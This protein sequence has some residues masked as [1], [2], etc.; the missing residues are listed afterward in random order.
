[1]G[2]LVTFTTTANDA[3]A[4][5]TIDGA[6]WKCTMK[7]KTSDLKLLKGQ[8]RI[9]NHW[10][11]QKEKPS[12]EEFKTFN[13]FNKPNNGKTVIAFNDLRA[14]DKERNWH[15]GIKGTAFLKLERLGYWSGRFVDAKGRHW[16]F[17]CT[18]VQ[19]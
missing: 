9:S 19:E 13:G 12:L 6:F 18:R 10:L 17:T 5:D 11:F 4:Q 7:P 16:S 1:M 14:M 8:F 15:N 3:Q 2:L